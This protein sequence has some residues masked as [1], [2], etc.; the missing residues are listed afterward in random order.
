V[1]NKR[2]KRIIT[3]MR[4]SRDWIIG[5]E[6]AKV[7]WVSDRTIRNDIAHINEIYGRVLIKSNIRLGYRISEDSF[8][9]ADTE[10]NEIIP[11][12]SEERCIYIIKE[13]LFEQKKINLI[14]LQEKLFVSSYTIDN[15]IKRIKNIIKSYESLQLIRRKNYIYL[16]GKEADKRRLYKH[17]LENEIKGDF[18]NLDKINSL[19][20]DFD[21]IQVKDILEDTFKE[22]HYHIHG[23]DFPILL[24]QIG[25]AIERNIKHNFIKIDKNTEELRNSDEYKIAQTFFEKVA[26][27]IQIEIVEDEIAWLAFL[28]LRK[29]RMDSIK[30]IMRY[31][32]EYSI[33]SLI[34]E[35]IFDIKKL[36]DIDFSYDNE[37]KNGLE[38]HI[39]SL[40][41][42][43]IKNIETDSMYLQ[44][45]KREYPLVFEMGIRVCKLLEEKI[46]IH[47]NENE[48]MFITLHLGAAYARANIVYK[49]RAVMIYPHNEALYNLSLQKI[50]NRFGDRMDIV[51]N[52]SF[53]EKA[54]IVDLRPDLILTTLPLKHDLHVLTVQISLFV[55]YEDESKIF[56]ALN[57]LDKIRHHNDF[58]YL[59]VKLIKKDFFFTHINVNTPNEIITRMC[60][61]LYEKGYVKE[62]FKNSVLQREKMFA[63]SFDYGF[64]IPH[65]FNATFINQSVLSIAILDKPI[66]WGD[67]YVRLV[68]LF[69]INKYDQKILRMFFDW[70]SNVTSEHNKFTKLLEAKNYKEFI[71]QIL[72]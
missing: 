34:E 8:K 71:D 55:N 36:F 59:A 15:D 17:L 58:E 41:E 63:T 5:K 27:K 67:F 16:T 50:I 38:L 29:R 66:K 39:M 57:N 35:I 60:N 65:S 40:L 22:Y 64:A 69:A 21:L 70:L 3:F 11:Q 53:F 18:L 44:E 46:H 68:I 2:Q 42:R 72:K 52:M 45:I 1:L 23:F 9:I 32:T 30:N 24:T 56:Q 25:I 10:L 47:I 28:L 6:L 54:S 37:L 26:R 13:L 7:F 33:S 61:K 51:E 62:S 12:T 20:K 31:Q 49:Y 48:I 43:H 19:Y 4:N 14:L